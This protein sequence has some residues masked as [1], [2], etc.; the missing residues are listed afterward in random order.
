VLAEADV[1]R[2]VR[3]LAGELPVDEAAVV[4]R[5]VEADPQWRTTRDRLLALDMLTRALPVEVPEAQ[6]DALVARAFARRSGKGKALA[7][8]GA[9][10]ACG[11]VVSAMYVRTP[12]LTCVDGEVLWNGARLAAGTSRK[13]RDGVLQTA[14]GSAT[15][16]LADGALWVPQGATLTLADGLSLRSGALLVQDLSVAAAGARVD[17]HGLASLSVEPGAPLPRDTSSL[18]SLSEEALM[19]N[20]WKTLGF[21]LSTAALGSALTVFVVRGEARLDGLPGQPGVTVKA[22]E[23]WGSG[24]VATRGAVKGEAPAAP[25]ENDGGTLLAVLPRDALV[26]R[27]DALLEEN[28]ALQLERD[29]L[30]KTMREAGLGVERN[31][32]RP[33]P[34]ELR[35]D[36]ERRVLR[37]RNPQMNDRRPRLLPEL[38]AEQRLTT[39][40][41]DGIKTIFEQSARRTQ[42]AFRGLYLEIGGTSDFAE[43]ASVSGYLHE[44]KEKAAK[45]EWD[46]AVRALTRER[47]G[48]VAP[49]SAATLTPVGRALRV[50][51]DEEARVLTEL[52][53]LLGP[54]RAEALVNSGHFDHGDYSYGVGP[55]TP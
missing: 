12:L 8:L 17:V 31:Y 13:V 3:W 52:D 32:Y 37:L 48:L 38:I 46:A 40:E 47:A 24:A 43:T 7:A 35:A 34:D 50:F 51:L 11:L 20:G 33:E 28:R 41:V 15:L 6:R 9:V 55:G 5:L 29:A 26:L 25:E 14:A 10:V 1:E 19:A 30:K 27:L 45:G 53:A 2:V 22:R 54:R 16:V 42:T 21:G 49:G 36:A 39:A 23:S 44:L 4:A 18:A